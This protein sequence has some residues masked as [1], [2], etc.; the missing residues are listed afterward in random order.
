MGTMDAKVALVTG[1]ARG[2]G[3]AIALG[4]ARAGAAVVVNDLYSLNRFNVATSRAKCVS[5]L[6]SS[7]LVFE[8]E[9][10]TPR[11]IQLANAFCR[12]LELADRLD[13][14]T[15]PGATGERKTS[16]QHVG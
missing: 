12:Y 4:L 11:Q 3:R 13:A 15:S 8:A 5:I 9:G 16:P 2:V 14:P 6:V 7:P 10:R 1:G